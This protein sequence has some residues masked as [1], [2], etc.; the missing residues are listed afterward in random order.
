M[1]RTYLFGGFVSA[2]AFACAA[3]VHAGEMKSELDG[4]P[5]IL[6]S[7]FAKFPPGA[8]AVF[9]DGQSLRFFLST[10]SKNPVQT[11]L[12]SYFGLIGDFE[13]S[14]NYQWTPV[15]VPKGGYG[16]SC[17]IAVESDNISASLAR[18]NFPG[19]ASAYAVTRGQIKEG[20]WDYQ[21]KEEKTAVKKGQLMLR[22]EKKDLIFLA[23]DDKG[24]LQELDRWPKFTTGTI[25]KVLL[26]ADPGQSPT[27]LDA[28]FKEIKFRAEALTTDPIV[29][30]RGGWGWWIAGGL[31]IAAGAGFLGYRRLRKPS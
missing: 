17:G 10:E 20:K 14:V 5:E 24:E 13:V 31:V 1:K 3:L 30:T 11:G 9:H 23:S 21:R 2:F 8:K 18:G 28:R 4:T 25:H 29:E 15:V 12:Y 22:R 19:H 26:F 16:V 7:H 6:K 27:D